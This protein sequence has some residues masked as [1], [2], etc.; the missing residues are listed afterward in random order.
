MLGLD[1]GAGD[2]AQ[3]NRKEKKTCPHRAYISTGRQTTGKQ[4]YKYIQGLGGV[5]VAMEEKAV[6]NESLE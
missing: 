3:Q 4:E 1:L 5:I 2:T 6:K